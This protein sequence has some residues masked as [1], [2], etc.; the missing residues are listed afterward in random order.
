MDGFGRTFSLLLGN[1][2]FEGGKQE[3]RGAHGNTAASEE[4]EYDGWNDV[5]PTEDQSKIVGVR[6]I[7]PGSGEASECGVA[8][9]DHPADNERDEHDAG[10]PYPE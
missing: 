5:E 3:Q 8:A 10:D 6:Y 9:V 2:A 4:N 7:F 1:N